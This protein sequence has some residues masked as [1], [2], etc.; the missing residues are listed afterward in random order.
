MYDGLFIYLFALTTANLALSKFVW[1]PDDWLWNPC[2][3][4][5]RITWWLTLDNPLRW[6]ISQRKLSNITFYQYEPNAA[7]RMDRRNSLMAYILDCLYGFAALYCRQAWTA[8]TFDMMQCASWIQMETCIKAIVFTYMNVCIGYILKRSIWILL[9]M[10]YIS[11]DRKTNK[12]CWNKNEFWK[13]KVRWTLCV[14]NCFK[15]DGNPWLNCAFACLLGLY[16]EIDHY[17]S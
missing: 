15:V 17:I 16:D 5:V 13:S 12:W 8:E 7:K 3:R 1:H 14:P 9:T 6:I 11:N 2:V 4:E 10:Q